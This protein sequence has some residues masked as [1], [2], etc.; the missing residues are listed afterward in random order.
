MASRSRLRQIFGAVSISSLLGVLVAI[1]LLPQLSFR[2]ALILAGLEAVTAVF[3]SLRWLYSELV[4]KERP[5]QQRKTARN[6]T[7]QVVTLQAKRKFFLGW[8]LT[9][10]LLIATVLAF[11][12]YETYGLYQQ[13]KTEGDLV[14]ARGMPI[15]DAGPPQVQIGKSGA[16]F[17]P[18]PEMNGKPVFI[19][20]PDADF[21]VE[22]GNF[23]LL[24]STTVRDRSGNLIAEIDHDH[25]LVTDEALDRNFSVNA[26][27]VMDKAKHV[28]F[29]VS[30][31]GQVVHVQGEWW[32]T[33]ERGERLLEAE[34]GSMY[35]VPLWPANQ[36]LEYLIKPMFVYPSKDH[37]GELAK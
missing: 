11:C 3:A 21:K 31:E 17:Q 37:L 7:P 30:I 16:I 24:V 6:P 9:P 26:F 1:A 34:Q 25:W 10:I 29:Q 20:F 35:R 22:P 33:E 19:P 23:G 5:K 12:E 14:G 2:Y 8:Q 28:V 18:T 27:E 4:E 13:R 36:H 32:S 15:L